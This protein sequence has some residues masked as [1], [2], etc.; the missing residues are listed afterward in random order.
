MWLPPQDTHAAPGD[1]LALGSSGPTSTSFSFML[2]DGT[3]LKI[4]ARLERYL[5]NVC[6]S[7]PVSTATLAFSP[8]NPQRLILACQRPN[9]TLSSSSSSTAA[10]AQG[11][12][13]KDSSSAHYQLVALDLP[14][15]QAVV[16]QELP[17]GFEPF[18]A[19]SDAEG[20]LYLQATQAV[21]NNTLE[22]AAAA[23]AVTGRTY[24]NTVM[25][26][27]AHLKVT[28]QY[29]LPV[30]G[31]SMSG[32]D[33]AVDGSTLLYTD[34]SPKGSTFQLNTATLG[35]SVAASLGNSSSCTAVASLFDSTTLLG[36]QAISD[37]SSSFCV[38]LKNTTSLQDNVPASSARVPRSW[39][40]PAQ[41]MRSTPKDPK[42]KLVFSGQAKGWVGLAVA[43]DRQHVYV[44]IIRD[45]TDIESTGHHPAAAA[46]GRNLYKLRISDLAQVYS[47]S[48]PASVV[49]MAVVGAVPATQVSMLTSVCTDGM[50]H[51]VCS[52]RGS[53][54]DGVQ[55][56]ATI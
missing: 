13:A 5:T 47:S 44:S 50:H 48:V 22:P 46:S 4:K 51:A 33:L 20:N 8:R 14:S 24:L 12:A 7:G 9:P 45:K 10:A 38:F 17:A 54:D 53:A 1:I 43:D 40:T 39:C 6:S 11:S 26:F 21:G 41:V 52:H 27:D 34:F 15:L 29:V 30:T 28:A 55:D 36:C 49:T 16:L 35:A 3:T 23:D 19:V 31:S 18:A 25:K 42:A 32:M 37:S 2:L 56:Y